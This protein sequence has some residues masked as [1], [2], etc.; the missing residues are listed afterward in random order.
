MLSEELR[1]RGSGRRVINNY[2]IQARDFLFWLQ[3]PLHLASEE[4]LQSYLNHV[5]SLKN[6][7]KSHSAREALS[8]IYSIL[9]RPFPSVN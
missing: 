4:E 8:S 7:Q 6:P 9:G 2:C 1:Q 5:S 3:K